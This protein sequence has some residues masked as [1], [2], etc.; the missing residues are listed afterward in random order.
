VDLGWQF[1]GDRWQC[2]FFVD[3]WALKC[4][5]VHFKSRRGSALMWDIK[6][7]KLKQECFEDYLIQRG[8]SHQRHRNPALLV[9]MVMHSSNEGTNQSMLTPSAAMSETKCLL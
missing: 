8:V 5:S 1:G 7:M 6:R 3:S 4:F 9:P 2:D